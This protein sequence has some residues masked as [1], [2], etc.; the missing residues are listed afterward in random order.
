MGSWHVDEGMSRFVHTNHEM[1]FKE[2]KRLEENIKNQ[3]V[4]NCLDFLEHWT[5]ETN[6]TL[7]LF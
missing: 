3:E 7:D 6:L 1:S 4:S 5:D 2:R